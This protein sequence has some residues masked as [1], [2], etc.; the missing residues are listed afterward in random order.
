MIISVAS[1][2][3]GTGKTTIAVNLAL[4]LENVQL[5]DCDVEEPNSHLF[6]DIKLERVESVYIPVPKV[7]REKC[8]FCG[9]CSESCNYNAIAVL[10]SDVLIFREL[11]HGCGL[12]K[13]VCPKN[14]I[15]EEDRAIGVIERGKKNGLE[16]FHGILS[17]GESMATPL[18]RTLK[19]KIKKSKVVILDASPG[20][21]CPVIETIKNSDYTILV[22]EPTPFGLYDLKLAIDVVKNLK[23]PFG[24]VINRDGIG[25]VGVEEYC[26]KEGIQVIMKIPQH[27]RIAKLYSKGVPFINAMPQ[28]REKFIELYQLIGERVR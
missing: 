7:D 28:W 11:C 8:D 23:I 9:M 1:G 27:Q 10:P 13:L 2:K 22:T 5:F 24:V 20:T 4:A 19:K 16:F 18:I 3:G 25:D 17:I 21:S 15:T 12:C 26:E 6:L 14:A